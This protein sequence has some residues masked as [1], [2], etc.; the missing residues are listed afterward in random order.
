MR[1]D[2]NQKTYMILKRLLRKRFF[3]CILLS[4]EERNFHHRKDRRRRESMLSRDAF[5]QSVT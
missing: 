4:V 3:K 2:T 5:P 1:G